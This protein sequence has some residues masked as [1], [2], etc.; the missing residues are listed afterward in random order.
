[1][2]TSFLIA[3]SL[4]VVPTS[5]YGS[6]VESD[7]CKAMEVQM[8]SHKPEQAKPERPPEAILSPKSQIE[9]NGPAVLLPSCQDEKTK[10]RRK[11]D[12]PLA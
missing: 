6:K 1:M 4:F 5:S 9:P 7:R 3:I 8:G 2:R 12:F 10:R 11:N